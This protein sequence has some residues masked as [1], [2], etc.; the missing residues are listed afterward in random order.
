MFFCLGILLWSCAY[1]LGIDQAPPQ[2]MAPQLVLNSNPDAPLSAILS[3][4]TNEPAIAALEINGVGGIFPEQTLRTFHR[5]PVLG[6]FPGAANMVRVSLA[7]AT[8]N[9]SNSAA[10]FEIVAPPLPPDFPPVKA[11]VSKPFRMEPGVT[12]FNVQ[13]NR[14]PTTGWLIAVNSEGR[15]V[16]YYRTGRPIGPVWRTKAGTLLYLDDR[17]AVEIDMLGNILGRWHPSGL[18]TPSVSSTDTLVQANVFHHDI[19][20]LPNGNFLTLSNEVRTFD[21]Y[22]SSETNAMASKGAAS[23]V[24][25]VVVEFTRAGEIVKEWHLLDILDPY[26]IRY[27][28]LS[29]QFDAFYRPFAPTRD[30]SHGNSISYNAGDDAYVI[31]MRHQDAVVKIDRN[32]GKLKWI[33]GE[34]DGW[35]FPWSNQTFHAV[36]ALNWPYHQHAARITS[37]GR[38]LMF[39]NG[40]YQAGPFEAKRAT[41]ESY[42]RA[43]EFRID[44]A[45]LTASESWS[46]GG[47]ADEQFYSPALGNAERMPITGNILFTDGAKSTDEFGKPTDA[48]AR[49]WARV[50]EVTN[51]TPAEKVF[52]LVIGDPSQP[53]NIVWTVYRGSHLDSF[54]SRPR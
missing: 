49:R 29:G 30:W 33:F 39:D 21:G 42:S 13:W 3:F 20:E 50:V 24:G 18:G 27:D 32:T 4:K 46:Y 10:Q 37:E 45:N 31:S 7:D 19:S 16:W 22:P 40:N 44:E 12:L 9:I 5:F 47:P 25:D 6:L 8:G 26:R 36:G 15:V 28:S 51:T 35:Q 52:E 34:P 1:G 54:Y 41:P 14:Q 53:S 11:T 23:V 38:L 48:N 43:V 2:L 17:D